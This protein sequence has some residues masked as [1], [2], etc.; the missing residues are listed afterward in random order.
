MQRRLR[1]TSGVVA[2]ARHLLADAVSTRAASRRC[3][4]SFPIPSSKATP[5]ALAWRRPRASSSSAVLPASRR[6]SHRVQG[7]CGN[8]HLQDRWADFG[9]NDR[10]AGFRIVAAPMPKE[11]VPR[12]ILA[13]S[14]IARV[15]AMTYVFGVPFYR[16]EKQIAR[17]G[18][19]LD[20][21]TMCRYAEH[22]GA[23]L[24]CIVEAARKEAIATAFCLSTDATGVATQP[25]RHRGWEASALPQGTLLR[26][27]RGHGPRLPRLSAEA[28]ELDGLEYVQRLLWLRRPTPTSSTTRSSRASRSTARKRNPASADRLRSRSDAS[29]IIRSRSLSGARRRSACLCRPARSTGSRP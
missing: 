18:F 11:I 24:G 12:G 5:N 19:P 26:H 17:E 10:G 13:P 22:V 28:H 23:T 8:R 1:R 6:R 14:M 2:P 7:E 15:L 25:T 9:S 27:A 16:F 3:V 29:R 4:S 20:R 21:G